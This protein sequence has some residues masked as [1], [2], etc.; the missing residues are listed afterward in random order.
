MRIL[1]IGDPHGN[2]GKI[3]KIPKR[4]ID[5]ILLT[6]D[7]GKVDLLR[8]ISFENVERKKKGLKEKKMTRKIDKQISKE[9]YNSSMKVVR[10]LSK[11]APVYTIYG[12]VEPLKIRRK[13]IGGPDLTRSLKK[14]KEVLQALEVEVKTPIEGKNETPIDA[15]TETLE[16]S[17]L[18]HPPSSPSTAQSKIK[19]QAK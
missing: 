7:L 1:A 13:K 5:L 17:L 3:R 8:K 15:A 2:M 6:G 19:S 14:M 18:G 9:V 16:G 4:G 12:N 10:Y 11:F